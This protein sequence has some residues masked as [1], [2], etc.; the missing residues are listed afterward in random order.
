MVDGND[1]KHL[2]RIIMFAKKSLIRCMSYFPVV[3]FERNL[4]FTRSDL[5]KETPLID[6]EVELDY[7]ELLETADG[8]E[9]GEDSEENSAEESAVAEEEVTEGTPLYIL[10]YLRFRPRSRRTRGARR[11]R[12]ERRRVG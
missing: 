8:E 7:D 10:E 1:Y 11:S 9:E 5:V 3:P 4:L 12:R 2:A 6:D